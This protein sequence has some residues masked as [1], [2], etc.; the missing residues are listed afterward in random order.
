MKLTRGERWRV[1]LPY[2]K[3]VSSNNKKKL[4]DVNMECFNEIKMMIDKVKMIE[5]YLE[6]VSQTYQRMRDLQAKT[7]ELEE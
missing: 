5:N 3:L 2:F 6:I 7:V 4:Y 1:I